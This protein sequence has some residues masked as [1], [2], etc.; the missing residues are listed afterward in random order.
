[1]TPCEPHSLSAEQVAEIVRIDLAAYN[2]VGSSSRPT[3]GVPWS[4]E[5]VRQSLID[6][7]ACLVTP[8]LQ[9]FCL[10]D[11]TAQMRASP[12]ATMDYWVVAKSQQFLEFYDA[13]KRE[14]GL[15]TG[16]RDGALPE[17]IGVRGDLVG[18]FG[19]M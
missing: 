10:K 5:K 3:R 9:R 4:E 13:D 8:Y 18:V 16:G 2:V 7:R 11:T 17:T 14:Y 12:P 15:A 1:M 6:L 19:A